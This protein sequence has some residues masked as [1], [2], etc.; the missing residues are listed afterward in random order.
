MELVFLIIAQLFVWKD[1][2]KYRATL[3][4]GEKVNL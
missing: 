2:W 4:K 1:A 3:V